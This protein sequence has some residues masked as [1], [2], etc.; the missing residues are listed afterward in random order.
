MAELERRLLHALRVEAEAG[1]QLLEL[2]VTAIYERMKGDVLVTQQ[3]VAAQLQQ[4]S[5]E[6]QAALASQ[7]EQQ[8]Q[9]HGA[10]SSQHV[11]SSATT[12]AAVSRQRLGWQQ[13]SDLQHAMQDQG[14]WQCSAGRKLRHNPADGLGSSPAGKQLPQAT[15]RKVVAQPHS[16]IR[17]WL[18]AATAPHAGNP[19]TQPATACATTAAASG[20]LPPTPPL[21]GVPGGL[22]MHLTSKK[23]VYS[24]L[25]V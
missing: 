6:V 22:K 10:A 17:A 24:T 3:G 5:G 9:Q 14:D 20:S 11:S 25:M 1:Q 23:Q 8:Q 18:S 15:A 16:K 7:Q 19:Q 12:A 21:T 4:L 2:R 13:P